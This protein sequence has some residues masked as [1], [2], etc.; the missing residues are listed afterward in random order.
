MRSALIFLVFAAFFAGVAPA[1]ARHANDWRAGD[2]QPLDRILPQ[3]RHG[4]AGTF[5]DAE[6]PFADPS[7]QLHYRIKWLTPE[8]RVIWLDTDARSGRVLGIESGGRERPSYGPPDFQHQ[9]YGR[10]NFDNDR[11]HGRGYDGGPHGDRH[12]GNGRGHW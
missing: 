11:G 1:E 8:G 7:G 5:Y 3:I 9:N 2:V 10:P 6:G 12:G 4:R